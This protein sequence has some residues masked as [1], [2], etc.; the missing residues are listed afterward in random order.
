[1]EARQPFDKLRVN[2]RVFLWIFNGE[3][4]KKERLKIAIPS[5]ELEKD[6]LQFLRDIGLNFTAIPRRYLHHGRKYAH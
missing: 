3:K 2:R 6:V 1:M 5:G 4:M